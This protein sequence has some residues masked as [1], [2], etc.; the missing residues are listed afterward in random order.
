MK[1]NSRELFKPQI[2]LISL[3]IITMI[4]HIL[5]GVFQYV[6]SDRKVISI[7][8]SDSVYVYDKGNLLSETVE[9]KVNSILYGM[10]ETADVR[11]LVVTVESFDGLTP[12]EYGYRLFNKLKI[13]N[14]EKNNG[15]L[16]LVSNKDSKVRLEVGVGL[17]HIITDSIAGRILDEK[18]VP[19]RD[20][21]D[22]NS[23][24]LNTCNGIYTQFDSSVDKQNITIT[25]VEKKES[26]PNTSTLFYLIGNIFSKGLNIVFGTLWLLFGA[27][28]IYLI[29]KSYILMRYNEQSGEK[30]IM[31][32]K[33]MTNKFLKIF[34]IIM[35]ALYMLI[36]SVSYV[37]TLLYFLSYLYDVLAISKKGITKEQFIIHVFSS[38]FEHN[39]ESGSRSSHGSGHSSNRSSSGSG[40]SSSNHGGRSGGGGA[41]R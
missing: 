26:I 25:G 20:I 15:L 5:G 28:L 12:E 32:W 18:F 41:T 11:L 19:Y 39:S 29:R 2:I 23:A 6:Y 3:I 30:N 8:E 38:S 33:P 7:N 1:I 4:L 40:H 17:E 14:S 31:V 35:L 16:L 27:L 34:S 36:P 37:V 21:G 13:G 10:E 22:Y 9:D 24:I